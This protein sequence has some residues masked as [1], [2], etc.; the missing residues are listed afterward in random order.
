MLFNPTPVAHE[1]VK[2]PAGDSHSRPELGSPACFG[3]DNEFQSHTVDVPAF[4]IDRYMVTNR[5]FLEFMHAGGYENRSLWNDS[6]LG[7]EKRKCINHPVFWHQKD[8]GW[9]YRGMFKDLPLPMDWPVYV[10]HA[11]A[12]AYARWAGKALPTEEQWHRAAFGTDEGP[13][14]TFPWGSETA[15]KQNSEISIF[16]T[17]DPTPVN[18]HPKGRSSFGVEGMLGNGWEWTSTRFRSISGIRTIS[19]LPWL[20]GR[21]F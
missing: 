3:W 12:A 18:A 17:W 11:E 1:M 9:A 7:L 4:E 2:V 8:E 19:V 13:E 6:R 5:Q 14:Q 15:Q 21:F 20:L 10:S 16:R